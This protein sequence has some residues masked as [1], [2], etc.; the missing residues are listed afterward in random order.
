M[1]DCCEDADVVDSCRDNEASGTTFDCE[2]DSIGAGAETRAERRGEV[3]AEIRAGADGER[4][5]FRFDGA[6]DIEYCGGCRP[7]DFRCCCCCWGGRGGNGCE[8]GD[9]GDGGGGGDGGDGGGG[10]SGGGGGGGGGDGGGGGV[11]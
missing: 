2:E 4:L 3:R 11:Y 9:G 7:W 1:S 8:G 6:A 10:N 5:R